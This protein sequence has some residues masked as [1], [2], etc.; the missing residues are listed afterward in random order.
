M[1]R[2]PRI[3]WPGAIYHIM[4]R[5]NHR[6]EIFRDDEDK[7]VYLEKI[8]QAREKY[9]FCLHAFCL[10]TNHVHLLLETEDSEPGK[11]MKS[12]NMNYSIFFN[13]K[14]R[15]VGQ[16]MQGR[17][18]AEI[19]D[20]DAYFLATGRYIHLNPVKAEIVSLPQ[21][22]LWSSFRHYITGQEL[23]FLNQGKT[24]GYFPEPKRERYIEF[25][26]KGLL[27][28]KTLD[29]PD[30]LQLDIAEESEYE[31]DGDIGWQR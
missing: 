2:K 22:Y 19:I 9:K 18:R 8:K 28:G 14:Y 12:I 7:Q 23:S 27:N 1:A 4:T 15:F 17:Y 29:L 16:L 6:H 21:D 13:K 26:L 10:M 24:L 20:N 11:I 30:R 5:G 3:W 31:E 25:T